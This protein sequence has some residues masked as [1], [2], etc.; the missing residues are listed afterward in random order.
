MSL[1]DTF[2]RFS[3]YYQHVLEEVRKRGERERNIRLKREAEEA[4]LRKIREETKNLIESYVFSL[5]PI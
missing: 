5:S 2:V 1:E 4:R 3:K